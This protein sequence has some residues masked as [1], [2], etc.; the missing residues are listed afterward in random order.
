MALKKKKGKMSMRET[1]LWWECEM[2]QL[3]WKTE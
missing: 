3:L 1:E 2:V